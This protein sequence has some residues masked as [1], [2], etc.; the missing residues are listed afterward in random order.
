MGEESCRTPELPHSPSVPIP[1]LVL[2]PPMRP[3]MLQCCR[4]P[5]QVSSVCPWGTNNGSAGAVGERGGQRQKAGEEVSKTHGKEENGEKKEEVP[6][7]GR[8]SE[9]G[10]MAAGLSW[11]G[12]HTAIQQGRLGAR[13]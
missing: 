6:Q 10:E 12:P 11:G 1:S 4:L 9:A 7:A 5:A 2:L 3:L 13:P 8:D